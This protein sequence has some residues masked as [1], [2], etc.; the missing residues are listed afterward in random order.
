[1]QFSMTVVAYIS[2]NSDLED[3]ESDDSESEILIEKLPYLLHLL[4]TSCQLLAKLLVYTK[5]IKEELSF[6]V[7]KLLIPDYLLLS[8]NL[9]LFFH[10]C[11][12]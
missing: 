3:C 12:L 1:M 8:R 2:M 4:S 9:L 7:L 10:N 5:T 6:S 11:R